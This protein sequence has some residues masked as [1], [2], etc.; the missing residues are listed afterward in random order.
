MTRVERRPARRK[1]RSQVATHELVK[2]GWDNWCRIDTP[3][4]K[5]FRE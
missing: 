1:R 3:L 5:S 4:G 2:A